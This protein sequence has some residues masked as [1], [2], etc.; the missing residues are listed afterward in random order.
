MGN[1]KCGQMGIMVNTEDR[2]EAPWGI[3]HMG[4]GA[5]GQSGTWTTGHMANG[6][7]AKGYHG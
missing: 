7:W 3:G 2:D 4:D 1:Q 5:H 6:T